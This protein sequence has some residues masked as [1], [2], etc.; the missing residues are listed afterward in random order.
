MS[1]SPGKEYYDIVS[2]FPIDKDKFDI[3][4]L[5]Y[6]DG[7]FSH[8]C[9]H[10]EQKN[11]LQSETF[12]IPCMKI[13][14]YM[15]D[16][17]NKFP[18]K[19]GKK[20]CIYMNYCINRVVKNNGKKGR[21]ESKLILGYQNLTS[22]LNICKEYIKHMDDDTFNK[23]Q[24]IHDIYDEHRKFTNMLKSS[25]Q[26]NCADFKKCIELYGS[27]KE[28]CAQN[29]HKDF[30]EALQKFK[31]YHLLNMNLIVGK[32]NYRDVELPSL[33]LSFGSY[34]GDREDQVEW[35]AGNPDEETSHGMETSNRIP[36]ITFSI[37]F[38]ISFTFFILYK[39][40]PFGL[41]LFP[42]IKKMRKI[43]LNLVGEKD[44]LKNS[45]IEELYTNNRAYNIK[46]NAEEN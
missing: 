20:H 6:K 38:I 25:T 44:M 23:V 1:E 18:V 43:F 21:N 16:L 19:D 45:E 8:I 4:N 14:T 10:I 12:H 32:C 34:H 11:S 29:T 26:P 31:E 3:D 22:E 39:F 33:G 41:W 2:F 15:R 27:H 7:E 24:N 36:L 37:I 40:T 35:D 30:C 42:R 17:E 28:T 5:K 9:S 46:Y 13:A